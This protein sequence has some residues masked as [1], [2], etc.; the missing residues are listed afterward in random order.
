MSRLKISCVIPTHGR[1]DFLR[2]SIASVLEQT[3]P[4]LELLIVSDDQDPFSRS[5]VN[6]FSGSLFPVRMLENRLAMGA[7]G[8]RNLGARQARGDWIA[9]LDDDDLW[10][11]T[12]LEESVRVI[13][14]HGSEC[15]VSW[16]EMFRGNERAPAHQMRSSLKAKGNGAI[17]PGLTGSNF[18]IRKST[19]EMLHGFD[20]QLLVMNDIDF[21]YRMLQAGVSYGVNPRFSAF[22]RKHDSGQ[23]TKATRMRAEGLESYVQKHHSTLTGSERRAL[24]MKYFRIVYHTASNP[25][26]KAMYFIRG[27]SNA[28]LSDIYASLRNRQDRHIWRG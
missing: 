27:L 3:Y 6:E 17:N 23:L 16:L 28:R 1:P 18:L 11:E 19:F 4:V 15:V 22:Q 14:A 24:R 7:S 9:F 12:Y 26:A 5:V 2:E 21:C 10:A 8:S 20:E 25:I 13:E